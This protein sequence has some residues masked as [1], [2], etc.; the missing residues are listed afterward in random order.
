MHISLY[1]LH[2]LMI[3]FYEI[4]LAIFILQ[5]NIGNSYKMVRENSNASN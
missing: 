4:H 1:I 2:C 3:R 5:E